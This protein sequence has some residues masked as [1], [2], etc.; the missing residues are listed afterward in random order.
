V[1]ACYSELFVNVK[2][3]HSQRRRNK[4]WWCSRIWCGGRHLD[5]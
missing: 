2:P 4:G 5:L 1:F 3:G